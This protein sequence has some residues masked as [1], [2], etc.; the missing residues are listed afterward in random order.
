[1]TY[2]T[3][4]TYSP[5]QL[6]VLAAELLPDLIRARVGLLSGELGTGKT[7]FVQGVAKALGV[8]HAVRSPTYT[9]INEYK[10]THPDI[11]HLIHIDLYRLDHVDSAERAQLGIDEWL[12]R[13]RTLVLIEWPERLEQVP[14]GLW[15]EIRV[16]ESGRE[17]RIS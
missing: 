17:V 5:E 7:T 12:N 11:D 13:P 6:Q 15:V 9:L 16:G 8:D 3:N 10:V 4:R 2:K 14:R 1:M